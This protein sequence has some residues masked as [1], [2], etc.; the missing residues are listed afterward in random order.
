[1]PK[2]PTKDYE[3]EGKMVGTRAF[4]QCLGSMKSRKSAADSLAESDGGWGPCLFTP[5]LPASFPILSSMVA[6]LGSVSCG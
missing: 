2:C 4:S 1:M 3:N 5:A 6:L